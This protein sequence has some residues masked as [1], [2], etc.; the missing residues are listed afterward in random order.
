VLRILRTRLPRLRHAVQSSEAGLTPSRC[1]PSARSR[2]SRS[3]STALLTR[4]PSRQR[5]GADGADP[6][7]D[8]DA[9]EAGLLSESDGRVELSEQ[10]GESARSWRAV[11][12]LVTEVSWPTASPG[13][14]A[15]RTSARSPAA[16]AVRRPG[17][18]ADRAAQAGGYTAGPWG[19]VVTGGSPQGWNPPSR[20]PRSA[21]SSRCRW[22]HHQTTEQRNP[23]PSLEKAFSLRRGAA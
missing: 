17:R 1:G 14:Q 13:E 16:D 3:T 23:R 8:D 21:S 12:L 9:I 4:S 2:S 15:A 18:R 7:G 5:T 11:G 22:R 10:G 20:G 19:A 6:S